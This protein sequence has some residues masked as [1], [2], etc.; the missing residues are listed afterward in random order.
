MLEARSLSK[1]YG[2]HTALDRLDLRIAPGEVF[3]LLGPNGAGKT[4]TVNLFL[5]LVQPSG[6]QALVDGIDSARDPLGARRRLA[7]IPEN[8]MLYGRLTGL[9]NLRYFVELG[10]GRSLAPDRALALLQQAGLEDA[11]HR[12]PVAGYSKGMRQKVGVAIALARQAQALLLDEPTS[13]L[14]PLAAH[15]FAALIQRLSLQGMAVLMVTHDLFLAQQCGTRVG[16]MQQG[17]LVQTL[18]TADTHFHSLEQA[19]LAAARRAWQ[20]AA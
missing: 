20:A 5:N 3:C 18:S 15:Q 17:R 1:L 13:G 12:Q 16:I 2:R 8:V 6:G 11:A 10:T 4:T 19:Y 9:E 14:D 7:Y